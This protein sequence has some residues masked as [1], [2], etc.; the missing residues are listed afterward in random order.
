ME[1]EETVISFADL[2]MRT[3]KE[4]ELYE[5]PDKEIVSRIYNLCSLS[6]DRSQS[7]ID[8]KLNEMAI[9]Q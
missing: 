2:I 4:L 1:R 8:D 3:I 5:T 6:R 7:I 9:S